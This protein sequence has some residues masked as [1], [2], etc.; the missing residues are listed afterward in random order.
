MSHRSGR[1]AQDEFKL[2][3]S[4]EEVTCNSSIEDDHGWDFIIEFAARSK[5]SQPLDKMPGPRQALVQVK[6]TR[7]KSPRTR[8]KVSNALK[9]AKSELPCF[10]ILFQY[11]AS[12]KH[13]IYIRHYWTDLIKHALRRGRQASSTNKQAHKMWMEFGFSAEDDHTDDA[14]SW[15]VAT[16]EQNPV[17]YGAKKR[18]L[19]E[20]LGYEGQ[21]F[22]ANITFGPLDGIE[23][24]VDHQL[25]L[26]DYLPV[27][28][29]TVIDSRFGIDAPVPLIENASGHI[30]LRPNNSRECNVVFQN[31]SGNVASFEATIKTPA[32]PNLPADK[33]K[34]L[35]QTWCFD[36]SILPG[37]DP[38]LQIRDLWNDELSI[39]QL[40]KFSQFFSWGEDS[41]TMKIMGTDLAPLSCQG[42]LNSSGHSKYFANLLNAAKM[43]QEIEVRAG[44]MAIRHTLNDLHISLRELSIFHAILAG[45]DMQLSVQLDRSLRHEHDVNLTSILGYFDFQVGEFTYFVVF[46]GSV[47]GISTEEESIR[48]HCGPRI[49]RECLVGTDSESVMADGTRRFNTEA[50]LHGDEC[51]SLGNLRVLPQFRRIDRKLLPTGVVPCSP[52]SN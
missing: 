16:I 47:T 19:Y 15:M 17:G 21:N 10:V 40:V 5:T 28:N 24:I 42:R 1:P 39:E 48:L 50:D 26:T 13:R 31:S 23:E 51:L 44:S 32:L 52:S 3:C 41:I 49:L 45:K 29:V 8:M 9:L 36:I 30:Q 27:S 22:R 35:I 2:L 25:G 43:L 38:R 46:D 4:R 33:F 37:C 18:S 7:G 20:T 11:D 6:S 14:I 12:G 34:I